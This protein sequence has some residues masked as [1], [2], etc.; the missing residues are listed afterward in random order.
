MK[1]VKVNELNLNG[2]PANVVRLCDKINGVIIYTV[3]EFLG[4]LGETQGALGAFLHQ[5]NPEGFVEPE[6]MRE[7]FEHIESRIVCF[8]NT[9]PLQVVGMNVMGF[10]VVSGNLMSLVFMRDLIA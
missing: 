5:A 6:V 10:I 4:R 7:G 8:C 9:G 3:R 2:D 1:S